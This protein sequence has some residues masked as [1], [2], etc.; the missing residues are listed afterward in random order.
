MTAIGVRRGRPVLW[1]IL[2]IAILLVLLYP[3]VWLISTSFKPA[4]EVVSTLALLPRHPTGGNYAEVFS[5]VAGYGVWH[6]FLNSLLVSVGA[7]A[8]NV[9]SCSLA[10]YAFGRLHFRGRGP[11]FGFMISTIMLPQHVVLIPQY[12][13]FQKLGMVNTFWPLILPKFLAT[14]AFFVFLMVQFV[15]GLPRELDEAATIDGCGPL[16]TFRYVVA[17]LLRPAMIT[18]AI[19]TFIWTWND[20]F[21]QLIYL[22][23]PSTFTLPLALQTFVDQTTQSAFG[24]MFAMSVLALVPIGLF[25]LAF[26][27]FLVDG[28]AT[29]GLK[30]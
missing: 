1:H 16:R 30:G 5:G 26:Q 11:M 14:D 27:R 9:I 28:A 2:M 15:R 6:Y 29:S 8:G 17:P 12:I 24:P 25:F 7:V 21:T 4:V 3:I 13:I 20:F 22:N 19:F 10:G 23:D 18:T